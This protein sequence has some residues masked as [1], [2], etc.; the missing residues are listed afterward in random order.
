MEKCAGI[1]AAAAE[2]IVKTD[3]F[4]G[5]G[6]DTASVDPGFSTDY[7]AHRILSKHQLYNLE[8]VKLVEDLPGN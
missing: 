3:K 5:V 2:W 8:N 7:K 1:S 6:L 4:Y